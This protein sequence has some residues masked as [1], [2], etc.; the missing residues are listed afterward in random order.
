MSG[1]VSLLVSRKFWLMVCGIALPVLNEK[2]GINIPTEEVV[3]AML[4][5]CAVILGIA[6]EDANK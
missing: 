2:F 6:H 1:V 5:V 4:A 3:T